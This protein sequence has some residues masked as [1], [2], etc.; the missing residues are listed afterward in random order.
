MAKIFIEGKEYEARDGENLLGACLSAGF[1]LPYFCW[2]PAMHSVGACR[3]CAVRVFSGEN[4]TK[5]RIVMSCMTPVTPGLRV[6]IEDPEAKGFRENV[7]EWLMMNHPHDCP[8]CDEGGECHLQDMTSMTGHVY[9][10]YRFTKRTHRNQYLGPLVN[11]EMNRCVQCYRCVRFYRGLSGGR[12]LDVFGSRSRVWF[13]R[14]EDGVLESPFAGNLVEVC[15]TGVFTDKT[16]KRHFA[17]KWDLQTAPSVCV[18]CA[19]GCN[20]IPGERYGQL[21]RVQNRY[22]GEVNGWFL[23]D[24][25]RFG[26]E[27]V[28]SPVRVRTPLVRTGAG[29]VEATA[30]EATG[31]AARASGRGRRVMA[32]GSPRASVEANFALRR[33]VNEEDFF[34]GFSGQEARLAALAVDVLANGPSRSPS[35][36]DISEADAVLVLGEDVVNTAPMLSLAL[37]QAARR[38]LAAAA[39]R[40]GIPYWDDSAVATATQG[41][42]APVFIAA[43][44]AT[45]LD[46]IA[47]GSYCAP[48]QELARVGMK[49]AREIVAGL[50]DVDGL[51]AEALSF[52]R[53]AAKALLE[54][55]RPLVIS[56][57]SLAS[58]AVVQAASNV[59]WALAEQGRSSMLS[60]VL[61]ECDSFGAALVDSR[62]LD[63]AAR[64]ARDGSFDTLVVLEND[65]YRRL[66]R[67]EADEFLASF[68][69]VVVIDHI[70]TDTARAA[71]V[72]LPSASFAEC[73]GTLVNAEGRAQRSFQVFAPDG[74]VQAAWRWIGRVMEAAG[75]KGAW[76]CLD[77]LTKEAAASIPAL[78][79]ITGAAP[80]ARFREA[81]QKIPRQ[82]SRASGRTA[83]DAGRTV[84]EPRPPD[85]PDSPLAFSMEGFSGQPP[86]ALTSRFWSPGW[87]S[88]QSAIKQQ[89]WAGGPMRGGDPGARLIEPKAAAP[90]YFR[91]VPLPFRARRYGWLIVPMHRVF[92][93]EELSVMAGA[94]S[95]LKASPFIGVCAE[96]LKRLDVEEGAP[97]LVRALGGEIELPT[98]VVKGLAP[99]V[100]AMPVLPQET[101]AMALPAWGVLSRARMKAA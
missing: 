83:A 62:G 18:H 84:F 66:G 33:L 80:S 5:G 10:R 73:S 55:K 94:L 51:S 36:K 74:V 3:Q 96:D 78:S 12:D 89:Q 97:A 76:E 23:C 54:A 19:V 81:G 93:S 2:H 98:V 87:N 22:N 95:M 26:Y 32:V 67:A 52:A 16:S 65:I 35:M 1:D 14:R 85:D 86:S 17:R 41:M 69:N 31:H 72:V 47:S 63:E 4:D 37:R 28:N 7:I 20:T 100:A 29:V 50:P 30:D 91:A 39:S 88:V 9:R 40:R 99:G 48:P 15:P 60:L 45:G 49:V 57:V 82:S 43:P 79:K 90:P 6:S 68:E 24:R 42:K 27:F 64:L 70:L 101:G 13:G 21:R 44:F 56:G 38:H 58:E 11:H 8:V 77:D 53:A 34:P 75:K 46:D 59:A 71:H 25:G 61:P 92:G